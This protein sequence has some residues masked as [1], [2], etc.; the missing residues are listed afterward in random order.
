MRRGDRS[1][2]PDSQDDWL[3][4]KRWSS[5]KTIRSGRKDVGIAARDDFL[6]R[7]DAVGLK[8]SPLKTDE[9]PTSSADVTDWDDGGIEIAERLEAMEGLGRY[10]RP[11]RRTMFQKEVLSA[12][13]PTSSSWSLAAIYLDPLPSANSLLVQHLVFFEYLALV[14]YL[15][16]CSF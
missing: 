4:K 6:S 16:E 14:Q 12:T 9:A 10:E 8:S 11:A 3:A 2:H 15:P 5:S 7:G 1:A 13:Y